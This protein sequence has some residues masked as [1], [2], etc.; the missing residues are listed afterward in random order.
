MRKFSIILLSVAGALTLILNTGI[1]DKETEQALSKQ[2]N[3][4]YV[5]YVNSEPGGS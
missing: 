5:Q 3:S 2:K 1:T 4:D